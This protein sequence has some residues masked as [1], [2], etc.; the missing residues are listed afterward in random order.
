[1]ISAIVETLMVCAIGARRWQA[2][3]DAV[4]SASSCLAEGAGTSPSLRAASPAF[5]ALSTCAVDCSALEVSGAGIVEGAEHGFQILQVVDSE[6]NAS[7]L[8]STLVTRAARALNAA[9]S[10]L[11]LTKSASS[12]S[13]FVPAGA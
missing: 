1:M 2:R 7:D 9:A 6:S 3:D 4:V 5:F 8:R 11:L 13:I 12:F 10:G